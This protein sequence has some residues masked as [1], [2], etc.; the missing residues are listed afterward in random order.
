M[1]KIPR[2]REMVRKLLRIGFVLNRQ[3]GSH[4]VMKNATG[5]TIVVPVHAGRELKIGL[6]RSI[7]SQIGVSE[8]E[9]WEI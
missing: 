6:F 1:A 9:F 2:G 8:E 3:H 5:E 7:F 4:C